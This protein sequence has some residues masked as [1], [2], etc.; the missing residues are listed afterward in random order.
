[1]ENLII[2]VVEVGDLFVHDHI[3]LADLHQ[4]DVLSDPRAQELERELVAAL[5]LMSQMLGKRAWTWDTRRERWTPQTSSTK[6]TDLEK[7]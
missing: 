7:M 4:K 6:L 1:L 3:G 2:H 5:D